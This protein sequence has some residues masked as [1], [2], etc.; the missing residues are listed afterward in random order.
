[1]LNGYKGTRKIEATFYIDVN[2]TEVKTMI[3]TFVTYDNTIDEC[4]KNLTEQINR[5]KDNPLMIKVIT[6]SEYFEH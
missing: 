6:I 2:K 5:Y 1:M 3:H 4:R